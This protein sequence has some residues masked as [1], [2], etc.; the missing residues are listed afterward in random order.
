MYWLNIF[1]W[2][3]R[4][5]AVNEFAS[6]KYDDPSEIPG[7][8]RG[9]VVLERFGFVDG[10]GDAYTFEWAWWS[11]LYS[12]GVC[13]VAV[14]V[15]SILYTVVRFATG[16]SLAT[17][18][19]GDDDDDEELEQPEAIELP[20]QKVNLTFRDIHYTVTSSVG[21]E[22]LELLKGID[23]IVE[24]GKMTALVS[25]TAWFKLNGKNV[26][27]LVFHLFDTDGLFWSWKDNFD[28]RSR[29]AKNERRN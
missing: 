3:L 19:S 2:A 29:A 5:L 7:K 11:V 9:E 12:L 26:L 21:N 8:T 16:L 10:N 22:K 24:A 28:G 23:G 15:S 18:D 6:G 4:G 1:A 13:V 20:F 17:T 25:F 14:I 27:T